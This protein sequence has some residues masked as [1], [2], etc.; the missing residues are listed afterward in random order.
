MLVKPYI[1]DGTG[2]SQALDEGV[3]VYE[4]AGTQNIGG[5]GL[6]AMYHQLTDALKKRI[7]VL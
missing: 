4:R 7:D 1:E 6:H 3:P 5:R 2:V